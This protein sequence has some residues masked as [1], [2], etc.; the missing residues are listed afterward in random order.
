M[1]TFKE[2]NSLEDR[3]K[4]MEKCKELHPTKIPVVIEPGKG[5][6]HL[7][8]LDNFKDGVAFPLHT[9][10]EDLAA[11]IRNELNHSGT[12]LF[13]VGGENI[14]GTSSPF[15]QLHDLY[16]DEDGFLYISYYGVTLNN[17]L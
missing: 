11:W 1:S 10:L 4:Q 17:L 15:G 2:T 14:P 16:K 13:L 9:T 5:E 3:R 8:G 12:L 6:T 7:N